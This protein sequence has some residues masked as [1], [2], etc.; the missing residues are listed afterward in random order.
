[1]ADPAHIFSN[2][3]ELVLD[4]ADVENSERMVKGF[5]SQNGRLCLELPETF[6][7]EQLL[8]L[9]QS[10]STL[11]TKHALEHFWYISRSTSLFRSNFV[12]R[13]VVLCEMSDASFEAMANLVLKNLDS[14]AAIYLEY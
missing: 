14:S 4:A 11:S 5:R 8:G 1:M 13:L 2:E 10:L 6:K 9:S 3:D 12:V 7:E